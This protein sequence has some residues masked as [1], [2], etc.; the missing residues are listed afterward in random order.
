[1]RR[2]IGAHAPAI[3]KEA[4]VRHHL[5]HSLIG[6]FRKVDAALD[7]VLH[8]GGDVVLGR[9]ARRE[10]A[11]RPVRLDPRL[12]ERL[13]ELLVD[14]IVRIQARHCL[15]L[16]IVV[17]DP[18]AS[19]ITRLRIDFAELE[20]RLLDHHLHHRLNAEASR[21]LGY[22]ALNLHAADIPG[23]DG[24][25]LDTHLLQRALAHI[26]VPRVEA[27]GVDLVASV[28]IEFALSL[29]HVEKCAE[30]VHPLAD[31]VA[32][33]ERR[34]L[35]KRHLRQLQIGSVRN[36]VTVKIKADPELRLEQMASAVMHAAV[37]RAADDECVAAHGDGHAVIFCFACLGQ[38]TVLHVKF[39]HKSV[40]LAASDEDLR[41]RNR[42]GRFLGRNDQHCTAEFLN[43]VTQFPCGMCFQPRG[44][45]SQ[46]DGA[47]SI[48][49]MCQLHRIS[50]FERGAAR[51]FSIRTQRPVVVQA[52]YKKA[53]PGLS[54]IPKTYIIQSKQLAITPT[55]ILCKDRI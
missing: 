30:V 7:K 42:P 35:D 1:M 43:V 53:R 36:A 20:A 49:C 29:L 4:R 15:R 41:T 28:H 31:R 48:S 13:D 24:L 12:N 55:C 52:D 40:C 2:R 26:A 46:K 47:A 32:E 10:M 33:A 9:R 17:L 37:V 44:V 38:D 5:S 39:A 11:T 27:V 34:A 18:L 50:S 8:T 3:E 14:G 54:I 6:I 22:L 51:L 25:S 45:V 21:I 19:E 23:R 16:G